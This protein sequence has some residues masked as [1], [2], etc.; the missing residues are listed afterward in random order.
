MTDAQR[1]MAATSWATSMAGMLERRTGPRRLALEESLAPATVWDP[2]LPG[3]NV[4]PARARF[5][6][7]EVKAG[8]LPACWPR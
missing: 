8:P 6:A 4:G 1:E 5:I 2:V 7:S 3:H